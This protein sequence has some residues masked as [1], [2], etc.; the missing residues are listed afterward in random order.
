MT[1]IYSSTLLKYFSKRNNLIDYPGEGKARR[2]NAR[3]IDDL[4]SILKLSA[5][6]D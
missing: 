3:S 6:E 5:S 2:W 1:E 4:Y